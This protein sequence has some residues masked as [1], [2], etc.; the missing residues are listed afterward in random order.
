[1]SLLVYDKHKKSKRKL[2][3]WKLL[4]CGAGISFVT[5]SYI[6]EFEQFYV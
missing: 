2:G 1:M 4:L 6:S 5:L 3:R